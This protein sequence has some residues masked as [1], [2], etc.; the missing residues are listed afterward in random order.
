VRADILSLLVLLV[1]STNSD[2]L[3]DGRRNC[4]KIT[5]VTCFACTY[6]QMLKVLTD[7]RRNC[8]D[9]TQFTCC[10]GGKVQMLMC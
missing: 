3:I 10:T 2:V 9:I 8:G 7:G 6:V 1:Q 4:G 5:Q